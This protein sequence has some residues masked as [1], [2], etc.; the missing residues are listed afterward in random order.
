MD[1][2]AA[3]ALT[4][5]SAPTI[6]AD[7][8]SLIEMLVTVGLISLITLFA[9]PSI[10]SFFRVSIGSASREL[11]G[12]IKEA[13]NSAVVTGRVHRLAIDIGKGQY[14]VES[15]PPSLLL[16]NEESLERE[17]RRKK[18]STEIS[19]E[20]APASPFKIEKSVTRKKV[21]LPMGVSFEDVLTQKSKNPAS[22]GVVHAHFFPHGLTERTVIHLQDTSNHKN[23]LVISPLVGKTDVYE[24]YT[25]EAEINS[26]R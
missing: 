24:R 12:T 21:S 6:R 1:R 13:Y 25:T 7:G 2:K 14:W 26:E 17:K 20:E 4:K 3:M 16:D 9:L 15:G 19:K 10:T 8:F 18:F 5:T 11:A 22:E 23:T